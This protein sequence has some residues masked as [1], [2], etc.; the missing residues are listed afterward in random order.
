[1]QV[2]GGAFPRFARNFGTAESFAT[3]T[4]GIGNGYEVFHDAEHPSRVELPTPR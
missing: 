4:T 2:T 3:A 1:M